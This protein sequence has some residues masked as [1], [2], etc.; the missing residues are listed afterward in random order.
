MQRLVQTLAL[1]TALVALALGIWREYSVLAV[2]RR[3]AIAYLAA[4]FLGG[5]VSLACRTAVGALRDPEPEPEPKPSKSARRKRRG[6][7]PVAPPNEPT[8]SSPDP[9][10]A[11]P[12]EP[13]TAESS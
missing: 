5:A 7:H 1:G 2:L 11:T 6:R 9:E 10:S 3:T 4:Y 8:E 12:A 13:V